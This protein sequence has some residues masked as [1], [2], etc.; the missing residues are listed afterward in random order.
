[1]QGYNKNMIRH[2]NSQRFPSKELYFITLAEKF[3]K[4]QIANLIIIILKQ[5]TEDKKKQ[6][7]KIIKISQNQNCSKFQSG[8]RGQDRGNRELIKLFVLLGVEDKI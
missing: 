8:S 2:K 6:K 7:K 5:E 1:M 4:S 3:L